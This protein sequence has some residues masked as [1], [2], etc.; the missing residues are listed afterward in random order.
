MAE[1]AYSVGAVAGRLGVAPETLRSWGRRYGLEPSLHTTGGHRRYTAADLARMLRMQ[2]L[3]S[4]GVTPA[5][6]A[7]AVLAEPEGDHV[8]VVS[9]VPELSGVGRRPGGP[10]GRVLAV[11]GGLPEARG[12][13]RAASRLDAEAV[14]GILCDAF[15]ERGAIPTWDDIVRPVL[16]AAG[17][18]WARTGAG[19]DVEHLLSETT[20]EALRAHRVC[21]LRPFPGRP[22]LLACAPEDLHTLPLHVVAAA[23][24][25]RRVPV[26]LLGA[27]VPPA[28]L[29]S[30]V[31]RTNA[32]AV[33]VW[34][35]IASGAEAVDLPRTRPPLVVVVGGPGWRGVAPGTSTRLAGSLAD[36]V[37]LL[38]VAPR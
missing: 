23:L 21:Q 5:R 2:R 13:A 25:E 6:A 35:Q 33:F 10:G 24:A 3:V 36:T 8:D 15:A 16:A 32:S 14:N 38:S 34:R 26:R 31:A 22:V 4:D 28:A 37:E 27:R 12:L 17:V 19:I 29:S 1:N 11:P 18:R 30:A 9:D 7:R 20:I